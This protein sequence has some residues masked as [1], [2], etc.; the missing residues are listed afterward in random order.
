MTGWYLFLAVCAFLLTSILLPPTLRW[1]RRRHRT[2]ANFRGQA[3]A[4]P[5]GLVLLPVVVCLALVGA[6]AF[7]LDLRWLA[8]VLCFFGLGLW[9]DLV[10]EKSHKGFK[11][12][13]RALRNGHLTT[14]A[15]K[16]FGGASTATGIALWMGGHPLW[17]A[18]HALIL[19][20]GANAL[21]LWDLRPGRALKVY[22]T[23]SLVLGPLA[24]D[25]NIALAGS[26]L[27]L[28]PSDLAAASM[29]GDS[30]ANAL[31]FSLAYALTA[32]PNATSL[33]ALALLLALHVVAE[34]SSL[35]AI[36]ERHRWL[37]R[38]DQLGRP[39]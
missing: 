9:D 2:E 12:H 30:G 39:S 24:P 22:L 36:I 23:L 18:I 4:R 10:G 27:A 14:G 8:G 20:L 34:A 32:A 11:G 17:I 31:G 5:S 6:I 37:K 15:V 21:N 33:G 3:T 38:L 26:A 29:I 19:A 28:L 13:L 35:T 1:L 16:L 7:R 25:E